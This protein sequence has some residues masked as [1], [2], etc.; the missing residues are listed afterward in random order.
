MSVDN[1]NKMFDQLR[2]IL[3]NGSWA[4][5]MG[6]N[7]RTMEFL[8]LLHAVGYTVVETPLR[9]PVPLGETEIII[10]LNLKK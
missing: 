10:E 6:E 4:R 5:A 9:I 7:A 2:A 3:N 1:R 8:S